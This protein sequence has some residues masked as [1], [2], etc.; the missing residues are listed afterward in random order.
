MIICINGKSVGTMTMPE[1]Q[2]EL[3][4]CGPEMMLVL[5]RFEIQEEEEESGVYNNNCTTLEDLAMDWN[6]IGAGCKKKRKW[7]SFADEQYDKDC[8]TGECED[9]HD[10]SERQFGGS[11]FGEY[12]ENEPLDSSGNAY[13]TTQTAVYHTNYSSGETEQHKLLKQPSN[14]IKVSEEPKISFDTAQTHNEA[15]FS[16]DSKKRQAVSLS[17]AAE[18]GCRKCQRELRTGSKNNEKHDSNC[19]RKQGTRKSRKDDRV[20][21]KRL[22]LENELDNH[23]H[24]KERE[25]DLPSRQKHR[26]IT[27]ADQFEGKKQKEDRSSVRKQHPG[28]KTDDDKGSKFHSKRTGGTKTISRYQKQLQER[29]DDES[30][31]LPRRAP[32]EKCK[33]NA[34]ESHDLDS[35]DSSTEDE[36]KEEEGAENPWLGC[37]CGQT[38]PHPIKVF[39]IQ[40]EGCD[41]WYDVAQ[42]CVGFDAD[43]AEKLEEWFCW[44]C[45][46]PVAGLGL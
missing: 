40:C 2:I 5:S 46:P 28:M 6:D 7:V 16:K 17:D 8:R 11:Q 34:K 13:S 41:A 12:E 1:L 39:W 10:N 27:K 20:D 42:E 18:L 43:A 26:S 45:A 9:S 3:E 37:V 4:V 35:V 32:S 24:E 19:P 29:S 21:K 14:R 33:T 44:A 15:Y 23:S 30:D 36:Y 25:K 38:H 31:I 22:Q